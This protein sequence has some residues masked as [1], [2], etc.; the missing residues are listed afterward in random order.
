MAALNATGV[1]YTADVRYKTS[2]AI[3]AC[4]RDP[5]DGRDRQ[6]DVA[7]MAPKAAVELAQEMLDAA[8]KAVTAD[9]V[10]KRARLGELRSKQHDLEREIDALR[11]EVEGAEAAARE[12]SNG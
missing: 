9:I 7:I 11:A 6:S 1:R 2:V 8:K 10:E 4:Q 5:V 3:I 12:P